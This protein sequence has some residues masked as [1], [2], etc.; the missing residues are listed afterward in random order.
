MD[1][2][3]VKQSG[4]ILSC[5]IEGKIKKTDDV[6]TIADNDLPKDFLVTFPL[7]KYLVKG[8]KIVE[9]K[10]YVMPEPQSRNAAAKD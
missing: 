2:R 5:V 3:F 6:I 9:N 10:E 7:G 4:Q 8:H 1:I